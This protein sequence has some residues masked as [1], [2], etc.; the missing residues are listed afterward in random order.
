VDFGRR[1]PREKIAKTSFREFL[2]VLSALLANWILTLKCQ[3]N[4]FA[5]PSPLF[6]QY[7]KIFIFYDTKELFF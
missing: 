4:L 7:P 6:K 3:Q 2:P 5:I 1:K